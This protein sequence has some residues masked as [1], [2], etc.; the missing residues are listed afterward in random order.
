MTV[1][2]AVD[3]FLRY[4]FHKPL[5]FS[6]EISVYSMIFITFA[7]AAMTMKMKRHISVDLIYIHLP[8]RVQRWLNVAT[9]FAGTVVLFIV[10]WQTAAW[11]QSNTRPATPPPV[12]WRPAVDPM[13]VIPVGCSYGL[14]Y[15]VEFFKAVEQLR[16]AHG[17]GPFP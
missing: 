2:V 4:F 14:Q 9:T 16:T 17:G 1:I 7:G 3:V 15:I 13:S 8:K 6:D 10:T 12:S 5:L 11:V